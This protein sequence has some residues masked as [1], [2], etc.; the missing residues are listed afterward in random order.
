MSSGSPLWATPDSPDSKL[1]L[2]KCQI[3]ISECEQAFVHKNES[4]LALN[5]SGWATNSCVCTHVWMCIFLPFLIGPFASWQRVLMTCGG[6]IPAPLR[7]FD[8][9]LEQSCC[10]LRFFVSLWPKFLCFP[11]LCP[12][13]GANAINLPYVYVNDDVSPVWRTWDLLEGGE[14]SI[15][16]L[17][18]IR[19]EQDVQA[20]PRAVNRWRSAVPTETTNHSRVDA[21][22]ISDLHVVVMT[23]VV[24]F[25]AEHLQPVIKEMRLITVGNAS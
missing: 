9:A 15:K 14:E 19:H 20:G 21:V 23:R 18:T 25:Q 6:A 4:L 24:G 2:L 8:Y 1:A 22:A 12:P 7:L 3:S 11:H 5:R 16:V 13:S 17:V 10:G